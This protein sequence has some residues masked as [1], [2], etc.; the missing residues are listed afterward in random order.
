MRAGPRPPPGGNGAPPPPPP[1]GPPPPPPPPAVPAN[2]DF[3]PPVSVMD[4][5]VRE[6]VRINSEYPLFS[7]SQTVLDLG[8]G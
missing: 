6:L 7:P 1:A 3:I 8:I 2:S 4:D 5:F